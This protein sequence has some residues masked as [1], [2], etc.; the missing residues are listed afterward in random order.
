M[1]KYL[2][3]F[4]MI[5]AIMIPLCAL[6]GGLEG[7]L[8]PCGKQGQD[9]CTLCDIF[10]M[11]QNVIDFIFVAIF[12]LAPIYVLWGGFEILT[13]AGEAGKVSNGKKKITAAVVGIVIAL[14]AW[15]GLNMGFNALVSPGSE[16]F[17]WPWNEV[18]CEGGGIIEEKETPNNVCTCGE[19]TTLGSHTYA[20]NAQCSANCSNYCATNFNGTYGCCGVAVQPNGCFASAP[21]GQWCQRPAPSG[22]DI[23]RLSGMNSNQKGDAAPSLVNFLNCMYASENGLR[24]TLIITSISNDILCSNPSCDTSTN[25]C[26]H[27]SNSCH[28]GG[29]NCKGASHAVDFR[30]TSSTCSTIANVARYCG[31]S[32]AWINWETNHL[33]VSL[34]RVTCGCNESS[35]PT[36]CP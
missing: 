23:W 29:T 12:I 36:P 15:T 5:I 24:N 16:G 30:A 4:L 8:V 21:P 13:S 26:G 7:P 27:T 11:V 14:V 31:G 9:P 18:K 2:F 34:D 3:G 35:N 1:K 22:S 32:N 28:F 20:T 6:A 33:H 17:P 19:N 25:S 10:I